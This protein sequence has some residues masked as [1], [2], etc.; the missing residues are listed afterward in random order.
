MELPAEVEKLYKDYFDELYRKTGDPYSKEEITFDVYQHYLSNITNFIKKRHNSLDKYIEYLN[1]RTKDVHRN[2]SLDYKELKRFLFIGWN[3]EYLVR[4]NDNIQ[5][6]EFTR[7]NNQWKPIQVYYS[8]YSLAESAAYAIFNQKMENHTKCLNV[9]SDYLINTNI[10]PWNYYFS[11]FNGN[12][13]VVGTITP[14]NFPN[15]IVIP[16]SLKRDNV[17]ETEVMALCIRAE[18]RHRIEEYKKPKNGGV[19]KYMYAPK[20][21]SLLHFFYRLRIKSNYKNAEV[22]LARAPDLIIT[23]FSKNLT[24]INI[25]MNVLMEVLIAKRI[26]KDNLILLMAEF[27]KLYVNEAVVSRRAKYYANLIT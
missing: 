26:G 13:K 3:T 21:T 17:S 8:I 20:P 5:N 27:K 14:G 18:H 4:M 12:K 23:D 15:G 6:V 2:S 10:E 24:S 22:F 25:L 7:I 1:D 11:G 19:Y 16:N 9:M